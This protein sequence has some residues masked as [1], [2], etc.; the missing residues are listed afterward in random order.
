MP[1]RVQHSESLT[2]QGEA[3]G[4]PARPRVCVPEVPCYRKPEDTELIARRERA[5]T[6]EVL[7]GTGLVAF[8]TVNHAEGDQCEAEAETVVQRLGNP[9]GVAS[10]DDS[11]LEVTD[12]GERLCTPSSHETGRGA[13]QI[14][15]LPAS[16][17]IC[18][19]RHGGE[20]LSRLVIIAGCDAGQAEEVA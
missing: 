18:P 6:L 16:I 19:A 11:L 15:A 14:H 10:G 20:T 1:D 13:P 7:D 2:Q 5:H 12:F 4:K 8:D 3:L 9:H 17:D